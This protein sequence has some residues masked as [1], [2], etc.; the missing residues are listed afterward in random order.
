MVT[1]SKKTKGKKT[2]ASKSRAPARRK[3][4]GDGSSAIE[5]LESDHREVENLFDAYGELRDDGEKGELAARICLALKV[6]TQIE[7]EIFYPEAR[8]ATGDDDLLDQAA[9]EHAGAK[10][11]IEEIEGMSPGEHLYDAKVKVLGEQIR[12]HVREEEETLFPEVEKAKLELEEIGTRLA[13]RKSE[14][15]SELGADLENVD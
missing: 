3:E 11:L 5:I 9:V 8:R 10:Q 4:A 14:L 1:S 6:H 2:T 15:M 12:H 13:Q 7:E